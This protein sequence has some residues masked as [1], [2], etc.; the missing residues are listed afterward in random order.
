ML[1]A[2]FLGCPHPSGPSSVTPRLDAARELERGPDPPPP[3]PPPRPA[4]KSLAEGEPGLVV[5]NP[6]DVDIDVYTV[7]VVDAAGLLGTRVLW[8]HRHDCDGHEHLTHIVPKQGARFTLPPPTRTYTPGGCELG[9]PLPDGEY[10]VLVDSG[11]AAELHAAAPFSLPMRAPVELRIEPHVQA[12]P[13]TDALARRAA[14]LVTRGA[15]P[16][17]GMPA[18][19][20]ARILDGC[21][22]GR[23]RCVTRGE[24]PLRPPERCEITLF[25]HEYGALLRVARPAGS[26]AL[27]GLTAMLDHDVV[28]SRAPQ[29]DRTS[30]ST[31]TVDGEQVVIAGM[32][33]EHWHVH[34]GDAAGIGGVTLRVDNPLDRPVAYRVEGLEFLVSY[35]CELPSEVRARPALL[36]VAPRDRLP[37]GSSALQLTFEAQS[38]YQGHCERF[39][40]RVILSVEG[41]KRAVTSEHHVGRFD[42]AD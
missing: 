9:P 20:A 7:Q 4:A 17:F 18:P 40:T 38:A 31:Y 36:Q 12:V 32:S 23:A 5:I 13:C 11:Y 27:R 14:N 19:I 42:V 24:E 39:A 3:L 6:G 10:V 29:I 35:S 22:L 34:G 25:T 41:V 15:W 1:L 33:S 28:H 26:D 37:P 21:D 8:P 16:S 30:S 2:L